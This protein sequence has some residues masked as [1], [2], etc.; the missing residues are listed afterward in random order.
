METRAKHRDPS[1]VVKLR[2]AYGDVI[3]LILKK[4]PIETRV[5]L[6]VPPNKITPSKDVSDTI[7]RMVRV[8]MHPHRLR[9]T[10]ARVE[11]E[12]DLVRCISMMGMTRKMKAGTSLTVP[13]YHEPEPWYTWI[14]ACRTKRL[15]PGW[16]YFS[17]LP[18]SSGMRD[19]FQWHIDN[20][21]EYERH[22]EIC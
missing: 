14:S 5:A 21:A 1:T 4:L 3:E 11:G 6:R 9:W 15:A 18:Y 7:A 22:G 13:E 12:K 10:W 16:Y 17:P 2:Q 8:A 20:L 19:V